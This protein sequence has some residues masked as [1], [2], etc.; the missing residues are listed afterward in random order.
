M[1]NNKTYLIEFESIGSPD[2][3]YISVAEEFEKIPFDIKRAYWT[4][5]TPQS[6]KRGGHANI[7]K[8]L[9]LIAVSGV[10]NVD[11]ELI[12]G[13]K[14]SYTLDK[15][16][17]GIYLPKLCWHKTQYSHNA[18]QLVLA[19]SLYTESDYIRDYE[20]FKKLRSN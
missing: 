8:E 18:V 15:P 17:K 4:Y 6:V 14:V 12:D 5:F 10:I 1:N 20:Q 13:E 19:S 3:G 9:V 2:I 16:D 11:T 7:D